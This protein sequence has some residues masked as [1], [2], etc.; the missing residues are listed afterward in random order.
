METQHVQNN[1]GKYHEI[2][3]KIKEVTTAR[4]QNYLL[5]IIPSLSCMGWGL[6]DPPY[7]HDDSSQTAPT[8]NHLQ[9]VLC[10]SPGSSEAS[11]FI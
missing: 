10:L 9:L 11:H 7:K 8:Q 3:N 4:A 2:Q 5:F 6:T 1:R